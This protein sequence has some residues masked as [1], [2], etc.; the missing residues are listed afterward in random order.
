M[1]GK[2]QTDGEEVKDIYKPKERDFDLSIQRNA[3]N[4][5]E[6]VLKKSAL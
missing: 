3:S 1:M 4:S 6:S 5:A 2:A